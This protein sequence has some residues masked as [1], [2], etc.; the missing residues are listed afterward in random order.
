MKATKADVGLGVGGRPERGRCRRALGHVS[1]CHPP[2]PR[3]GNESSGD[4][5]GAAPS[6]SVSRLDRRRLGLQGQSHAAPG[7]VGDDEDAVAVDEECAVRKPRGV[8]TAVDAEVVAG[9][10][11]QLHLVELGP[12]HDN[13]VFCE[14]NCRLSP[15]FA[16][17]NLG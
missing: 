15:Q 12:I 9:Q 7:G 3:N 8:H 13:N 4:G 1:T 5:Q 16:S 17:E 10:G 2:Q 14:A 11:P 6:P